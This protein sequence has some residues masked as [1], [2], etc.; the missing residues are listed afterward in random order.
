MESGRR[1]KESTLEG[2]IAIQIVKFAVSASDDATFVPRFG[3]DAAPSAG[4]T[5][6]AHS[7]ADLSTTLAGSTS[8]I[9]VAAWV[10]IQHL[11]W[12]Q[13]SACLAF[14]LLKFETDSASSGAKWLAIARISKTPPLIDLD[15]Q[16]R[17]HSSQEPWVGL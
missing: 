9:S 11:R 2:T 10:D 14:A 6:S 5:I 7:G 15:C 17:S 13:S 4:A 12:S 3:S 16:S 1:G 8:A